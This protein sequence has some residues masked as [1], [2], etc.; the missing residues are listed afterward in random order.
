MF[1]NDRG[2]VKSCGMDIYSSML[3][4]ISW[5]IGLYPLLV[6]HSRCQSHHSY[7]PSHILYKIRYLLGGECMLFFRGSVLVQRS[8]IGPVIK[9]HAHPYTYEC[10]S[11][12]SC[13]MPTSAIRFYHHHQ[14]IRR[15]FPQ[16]FV[17]VIY[18]CGLYSYVDM[19]K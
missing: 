8:I 14:Y 16:I 4:Y 1:L 5:C 15:S 17:M 12:T 19:G 6:T 13:E 2:L 3:Y 10:C 7:Q 11:C 9:Y 18:N